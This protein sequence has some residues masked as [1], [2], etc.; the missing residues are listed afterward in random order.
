M[1]TA[2][3][4]RKRM[5]IARFAGFC[6]GVAMAVKGAE[7]LLAENEV[8]CV[9]DIIHNSFVIESLK[10]KGLK[11]VSS[12]KE[13]PP[14][15]HMIIRAHGL[16]LEE[17]SSLRKKGCI[18]HDFTCPILKK[19]HKDI[20]QLKRKSYEIAIIGNPRHA[21]VKAFVSRAGEKVSVIS[22]ALDADALPYAR[23][24]AIICQSTISGDLFVS[25]AAK[26]LG[27]SAR[28]LVI[29]TICS[30]AKKRRKEAEALAKKSK[31]V[32]IVGDSKS[33]NTMT[34]SGIVGKHCAVA[35]ISSADEIKKNKI[36]YPLA[37]VSGASSPRE[38]VLDIARKVC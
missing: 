18:V 9:G 19:I 8:Y 24:R 37:I 2:A 14:R 27:K 36:R 7:K 3:K 32:I 16:P 30:E 4:K 28:T 17:I 29:D 35:L 25:L 23:C 34:L 13:I 1:T 33:S 31:M 38:L 15:S 5:T 20:I 12:V 6:G 22:K 11:T 10:K 26:A 21:E